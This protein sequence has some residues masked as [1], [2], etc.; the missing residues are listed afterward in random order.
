MRRLDLAA[1]SPLYQLFSEVYEGLA[2]VRGY[3][4]ESSLLSRNRAL[5]DASQK[6]FF[7]RFTAQ[8]WLSLYLNLIVMIIAVV[9]T[10]LAVGLRESVAV[11]FLGVALSSLVLIS[12]TLN[13]ILLFFTQV[14]TSLVALERV[15]EFTTIE[16]EGNKDAG[17]LAADTYESVDRSWPSRGSVDFSD[18]VVRYR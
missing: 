8:A 1:K 4:M 3:R 12:G 6:P 2:S 15:M 17:G 5:L 16:P 18:V 7:L 10:G 9:L 14:E 11:G 13:R